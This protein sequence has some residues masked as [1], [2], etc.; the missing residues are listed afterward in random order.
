MTHDG[1]SRCE[2]CDM[3]VPHDRLICVVGVNPYP[4][5]PAMLCRGCESALNGLEMRFRAPQT[6]GNIRAALKSTPTRIRR[7]G[8]E[9]VS[10][11]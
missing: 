8:E 7:S 4:A 3:V 1:I 9:N 6:L 2:C 11:L 10:S 5:I